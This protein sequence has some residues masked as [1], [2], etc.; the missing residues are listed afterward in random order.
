MES[1]TSRYAGRR[2]VIIGGT[3]GFGRTTAERLVAGGGRVM[4]TGRSPGKVAETVAALGPGAVGVRSDASVMS[5]VDDLVDRVAAEFQ[6]VDALFVN[7]GITRPVAFADMTED[8]Y[9]ELF[10]IN[11]KGPYFTV[12]RLA[13]LLVDGAGV[14]LTTSVSDVKGLPDTSVYAATKAALRSMA[15]TLARELAGR[16]I[17]VNAVSPGPIDTGILDRALGPDRVAAV[18]AEMAGRNP[19]RRLGRPDE[20]AA[21]VLFLAFEATYTTGSE[22]AVDG[23]VA[24]L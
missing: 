13:P 14:V 12:Q 8:L 9:D 20:V 2:V 17:R 6:T 5:D 10:A 4:V 19:M 3:S 11:T 1:A 22:L 7:A 21:A 18:K 16:N 15:R 23:G 24:Q